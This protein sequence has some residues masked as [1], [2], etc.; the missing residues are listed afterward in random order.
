MDLTVIFVVAQRLTVPD[1]L[2][3]KNRKFTPKS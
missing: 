1:Q 2:F 3:C